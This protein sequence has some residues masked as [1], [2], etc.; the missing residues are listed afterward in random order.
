MC[1][2]VHVCTCVCVFY[3][4]DGPMTSLSL[5][6][7]TPNTSRIPLNTFRISLMKMRLHFKEDISLHLSVCGWNPQ[8]M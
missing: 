4:L 7:Q 1:V 2:C 3:V 5:H 8:L 6:G